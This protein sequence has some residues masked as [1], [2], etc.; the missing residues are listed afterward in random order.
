M[1]G[2]ACAALWALGGVCLAGTPVA[3]P[4]GEDPA[5]WLDPLALHDLEVGAPGE[6]ARVVLSV[7]GGVWRAEVVRA[8]AGVFTLE[9]LAPPGTE[10][11][12]EALASRLASVLEPVQFALPEPP[13]PSG[14][15]EARDGAVPAEPAVAVTPESGGA[16]EVAASARSEASGAGAPGGDEVSGDEVSGDA[17]GDAGGDEGAGEPPAAAAGALSDEAPAVALVAADPAAASR[18]APL[19]VTDLDTEEPQPAAGPGPWLELGGGG[20]LRPGVDPAAGARL[21]AGVH[22]ERL[23]IGLC[24]GWSSPASLGGVA[25]R[26]LTGWDAGAS[27]RWVAVPGRLL[28]LDLGAEAV[29]GQ[30]RFLQED[31][32]VGAAWIPSAAAVVAARPLPERA[33]GAVLYARGAVDLRPGVYQVDEGIPGGLPLVGLELGVGARVW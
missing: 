4:P 8:G 1:R 13:A 32:L 20:W 2:A 6:G 24:G 10:A 12:R 3:L 33:A 28:A 17:A 15:T 23:R 16:A 30:R 14:A 29:V 26:E 22:G 31:A 21:A 7:S 9:G 18:G 19:V 25:A 5:A 11:E 27:A